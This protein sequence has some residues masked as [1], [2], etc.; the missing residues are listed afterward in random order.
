[1]RLNECGDC[2]YCVPDFFKK[3]FTC[4]LNPPTVIDY[5]H[6]AYPVVRKGEWGCSFFKPDEEK[7]YK[8]LYDIM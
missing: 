8:E 7:R 4:H 5:S 1:M 2:Y 6:S 3:K